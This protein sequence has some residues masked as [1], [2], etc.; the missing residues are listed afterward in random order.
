[1]FPAPSFK[2]SSFIIHALVVGILSVA[3]LSCG[4]GG[5]SSNQ[6]PQAN[7]GT[8]RSAMELSVVNLSGAASSDKDGVINQ[9][10]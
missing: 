4:G 10:L 6:S 8:D 7:A 9:Y 1:M 5:G 3:I 2:N